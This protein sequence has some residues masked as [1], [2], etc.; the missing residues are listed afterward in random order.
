MMTRIDSSKRSLGARILRIFGIT[1]GSIIALIILILGILVISVKLY[2]PPNPDAYIEYWPKDLSYEAADDIALDLVSQMSLEEKLD[3]MTGDVSML[4]MAR[5]GASYLLFG[6]LIMLGSGENER[7]HIPP[8]TFSDGPRGIVVTEATTFPV[9]MAQGATWDTE[10]EKRLGDA[11][12]KEARAAGA[13]YFGGVCINLLRHPAWGRAQETFG[14]DPWHLGRMGISLINGVQQHNVMACPKHYALN[15]IEIS[16]FKVDVSV[17]ERTLREVYLPHFKM[18]VKDAGAASIMSA[19]NKVRGEFCG[20]N[21]YLLTDILRNDWGFDGFVSSDWGWGLRDG[22]K[23][24][25]AGMDVEMPFSRHY[26]KKEIEPALEEGTISMEQI[27]EIVRRIVRT[28]LIWVTATDPLE[29][30]KDLLVSQPHQELALEVAEKSMVL[31]QNEN[32]FLPLSADQV[33]TLAVIG[34]LAEEENLGDHGSSYSHSPF[35]ITILQGL[36]EYGEGKFEVVFDDGSDIESAR[37]TAANADVAVYVVGY[38]YNDEGE[39]VSQGDVEY[40][41]EWGRGG[42][43]PNLY[44]KPQHQE[45]LKQALP[46]NKNSV[47]TLIGGSGIMTNDWNELTP[48]ILVAWYPGMMGGEAVAN[49]LFGEVNPSGKLPLTIPEDE[50][51][52]PYFY[53]DVE[54]IEYGYYHGYTLLDK[55]DIEPAYPFGY[56]LSYTEF[57]YDSLQLNKAVLNEQDTLKMSVQVTNTGDMS[58]DEI[59][60]V[61]VGFKNSIVNRPAKL[62]RGFNRASLPPGETKTITIPVYTK[63]LA[64]YNPEI[65]QWVI[66]AMEYEVYVGSSSDESNL[67][68]SSFTIVN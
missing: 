16:R 63:D 11:I 52:L 45:L 42:D 18:A 60:Q 54:A 21:K 15:S 14:E 34:E 58:G 43:R 8:F 57:A 33:N 46:E 10:L 29:Y 37:Q 68:K 2:R 6:E 26:T 35:V 1:L 3:Q 20:H 56:G 47:V 24:I 13:N 64:W 23:G 19:Y 41:E 5:F 7:L 55:E 40:T 51:H 28:K 61:Y 53:P 44:L 62:L 50:D 66:D 27:D 59:V 25:K 48:S 65:H 4:G 32:D 39:Y 31:L 12:G 30:T 36:Q 38:A 67:L 49:I 22:V 9:A 17:D